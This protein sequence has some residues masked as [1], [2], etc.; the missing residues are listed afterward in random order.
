MYYFF[1]DMLEVP[2][3]LLLFEKH[4]ST[5]YIYLLPD[6]SSGQDVN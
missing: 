3:G 2:N 6:L 4:I 1:I 5:I